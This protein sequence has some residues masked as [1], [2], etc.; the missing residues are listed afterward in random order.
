MIFQKFIAIGNLVERFRK[1]VLFNVV[2]C[3]YFSEK[4]KM[5][6]KGTYE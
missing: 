6:K 3:I 4:S 1:I 2:L 5:I